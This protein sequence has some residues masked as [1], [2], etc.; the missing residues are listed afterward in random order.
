MIVVGKEVIK[1]KKAIYETPE[2]MM[3]K[4]N[5]EDIMAAS[6]VTPT[7]EHDKGIDGPYVTPILPF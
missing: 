3:D 7:P 4:F 2:I 5:T 1:M 6:S